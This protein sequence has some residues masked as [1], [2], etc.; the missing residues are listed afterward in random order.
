MPRR[1]PGAPSPAE[2]GA[3]GRRLAATLGSG[4]LAVPDGNDAAH[5]QETARGSGIPGTGLR[6]RTGLRAAVL[7]AAAA[8]LLC[9]WFWWSAATGAPEVV[10]LTEASTAQGPGPG[11][12]ASA[13]TSAASTAAT[14]AGAPANRRILV[15]VAGAVLKPGVVELPEGSRILEA[16]AAA[17]GGGATADPDRLNLA[18]VVEDG[19]KVLVPERGQ[20]VAGEPAAGGAAG[21]ADPAETGAG[22]NGGAGTGGARINL[23]TAGVA[24]LGTLPRVGP[25]LAQRI[26][27]WRQEHGRFQS[28]EELDAV[29]GVGPKLLAAL[30][31]LVRV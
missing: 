2:P 9:G 12:D 23:N 24:E 25:V 1:T 20:D 6:W 11:R 26:V 30:L 3:A 28:V 13:G 27:D 31:P 16:I 17:G 21:A 14:G 19:Q 29:E 10:P 4:L 7:L 5:G 8:L 22:G 18:A 15:H